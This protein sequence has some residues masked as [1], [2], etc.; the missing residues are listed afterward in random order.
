MCTSD[1]IPISSNQV[2]VR[3]LWI[4]H[5]I[6]PA[7]TPICQLMHMRNLVLLFQGWSTRSSRRCRHD[8]YD[9]LQTRFHITPRYP[10]V[11]KVVA[12][13]SW[14]GHFSLELFWTSEPKYLASLIEWYSLCHSCKSSVVCALSVLYNGKWAVMASHHIISIL[15]S[16]E[17]MVNWIFRLHESPMH[18]CFYPQSSQLARIG[19]GTFRRIYPTCFTM[20]GWSIWS[21]WQSVN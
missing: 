5:G 13:L 19:T 21:L 20:V 3:R 6:G 18:K 8:V 12:I 10:C 2:M 1:W 16:K 4:K 17:A 7:F 9:P 11:A 14:S 15:P